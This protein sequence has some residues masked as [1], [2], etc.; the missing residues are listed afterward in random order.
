MPDLTPEQVHN[1]L[2]ALGLRTLDEEDLNE[3]THRINALRGALAAL[4]PTDL[5]E[6]EPLSVFDPRVVSDEG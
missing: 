5:D 2:V 4:E 3:V 6:Q 1:Q